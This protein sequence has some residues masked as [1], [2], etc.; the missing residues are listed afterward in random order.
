MSLRSKFTLSI[1]AFTAIFSLFLFKHWEPLLIDLERSAIIE[2]EKHALSSLESILTQ[3]LL[4]GDLDGIHQT[5]NHQMDSHSYD[6]D[7]LTLL[8]N[9]GHQLFLS[10]NSDIDSSNSIELE[11]LIRSENNII[12]KL[13]VTVDL[14]PALSTIKG[15]ITHLNNSLLVLL[16][17][18]MSAIFFI[19]EKLFRRPLTN[20]QQA[21]S[22]IEKGNLESELPEL[23]RNDEIGKLTRAFNR[24]KHSLIHSQKALENSLQTETESKIR[25]KSV[26]DNVIDGIVITDKQGLILSCNLKA[27]DIFG[28]QEEELI[29]HQ[30][31][32]LMPSADSRAHDG[33]MNNYQ[34]TNNARIIGIGRELKGKRKDGSTFPIDLGVN[35]IKVKQETQFVGIIRDITERKKIEQSLIASREQ[36]EAASKAKSEFL[37]MISHELRTP[38]NG[39]I[40]MAQLMRDG[41]LDNEQTEY[42]NIINDSSYSLLTIIDDILDHTKMESGYLKVK[43][44]IFNLEEVVDAVQ[45]LLSPQAKDKALVLSVQL[46]RK[47]PPLLIGDAGRIRQ[48]L[49]NLLGN[50]IKFTEQGSVTL[51]LECEPTKEGA[52]ILTMTISDTGIGISDEDQKRL[53]QLFTQI[54]SSATRKYS[55][56]GLGLAISKQLVN[57]MGGDISLQSTPDKGSIF[58]VTLT[59]PLAGAPDNKV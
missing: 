52:A 59:L 34:T 6:W 23:N 43:P 9:E 11:Q 22:D 40:G 57:Q 58:C 32:M 25:Y 50:A 10:V 13:L 16:L 12:G 15:H 7:K 39:V 47:C 14:N 51:D 46:T 26:I 42:L 31:N 4:A 3:S 29:N 21:I 45:T 17:A 19:L 37:A 55:G 49:L 41:K 33:H 54:D 56:T 35:E 30:I 53:F 18:I 28:Y 27:L 5:L 36:A 1:I 20:L 44:E 24:M 38:L 48:V 2:D 8:D